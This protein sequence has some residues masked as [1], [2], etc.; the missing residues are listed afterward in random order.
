[1]KD[2]K[3][4][5]LL[6][7]RLTL[8]W[9]MFYAGITKV[10]DPEWTSVGYLKG[11]KTFAGFYAWLTAPGVIDVVD[12]LNAWGLTLLGVSLILGLFV[13]LSS[14][15]GAALMLLYWFPVLDFPWVAHGFLVDDHVIYAAVLLHL[16]AVKAGRIGW[17]LESR[18]EKLPI[19]AKYPKLREWLG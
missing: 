13:R 1:M 6:A 5:S 19:C 16:A 7:I 10:L 11:A 18:C 9:L 12:V 3:A 15:L 2:W 4:L 8:G 14:L 17:G